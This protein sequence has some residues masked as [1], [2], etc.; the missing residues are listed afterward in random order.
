MGTDDDSVMGGKNFA[1][2]ISE[3]KNYQQQR[4]Y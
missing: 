3:R 2:N 4:G 1:E